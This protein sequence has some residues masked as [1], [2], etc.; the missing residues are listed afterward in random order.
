MVS[1]LTGGQTFWC[2]NKNY[3]CQVNHSGVVVFKREKSTLKS[4]QCHKRY[5]S[6]WSNS[7]RLL[8]GFGLVDIRWD[9]NN[10]R[11]RG[12]LIRLL[13]VSSDQHLHN[14]V[15]CLHLSLKSSLKLQIFKM[16]ECIFTKCIQQRFT[17]LEQH[18]FSSLVWDHALIDLGVNYFLKIQF[19][20]QHNAWNSGPRQYLEQCWKPKLLLKGFV[21]TTDVHICRGLMFTI[22]C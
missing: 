3:H 18:F 1:T 19:I 6:F 9:W 22:A 20:S 5:F 10:I 13:R 4:Y 14:L 16:K 8:P 15:Y 7:H 17:F 12:W 2:F 11:C 21:L